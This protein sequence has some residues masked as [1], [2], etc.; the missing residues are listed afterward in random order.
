MLDHAANGQPAWLR[1]W[2]DL[3]TD[4]PHGM[5]TAMAYGT[6]I[7][8]TGIAL[9]LL[10]GFA[11]KSVYLVGAVYSLLI[12]ATAEGFGGP[13]QSGTTDVGAAIIYTF[14]FMALLIVDRPGPDP[15][16]VDAL[17]EPRISWWSRI[18]EV[19]GRAIAAVRAES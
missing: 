4:M 8:E 10:A 6:A 5:A 14:V 19:R 16:S 11:R 18:A 1:P 2:F 17:L 9:A 13:Y 3:W 15:Y 12:W 7:V